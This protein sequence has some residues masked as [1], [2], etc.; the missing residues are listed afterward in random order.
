MKNARVEELTLQPANLAALVDYQNGSIVSRKIIQKPEGSVT[1]FAFDKGQ[2]L[3]THSA[4]YDALVSLVDGE[5]EITIDNKPHRVGAGQ[6]LMLPA[7]H[8]HA[9]KATQRFKMLLIMVR[10]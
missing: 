7:S 4:P 1:L 6:I 2:E 8:P 3:N 9:V 5:A 10:S